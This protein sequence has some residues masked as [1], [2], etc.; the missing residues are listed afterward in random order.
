MAVNAFTI[1]DQHLTQFRQLVN[2]TLERLKQKQ[3]ELHNLLGAEYEKWA[4]DDL[5]ALPDIT[6]T[7]PGSDAAS[8][9]RC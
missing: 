9:T 3:K 5:L 4:R 2:V 6:Y 7:V 1:D 8:T